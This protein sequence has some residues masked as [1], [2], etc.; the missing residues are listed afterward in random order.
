MTVQDEILKSQAQAARLTSLLELF[1]DLT[2]EINRWRRVFECSKSVN[3]L[4]TDYELAH[5]CGC[6]PDPGVLVQVYVDTPHGRVY[7]VPHK[8]EVGERIDYIDRP[9]PHWERTLRSCGISEVVIEKVRAHFAVHER[10]L[11]EGLDDDE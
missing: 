9:H 7:G 8:I 4:A 6:C 10:R 1:P 2:Q 11:A 5:T 3:S